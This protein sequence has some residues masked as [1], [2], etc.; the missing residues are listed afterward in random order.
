VA[1]T[2]TQLDVIASAVFCD[3][4]SSGDG[5]TPEEAKCQDTTAKALSNFASKKGLCYRKCRAD[6]HKGKI[7]AGSCTPPASDP[8][9]TDCIS[10]LE[11]KTAT[12]ID[13]KCEPLGGDRP[14]CYGSTD[15]AGWAGLVETGVDSASGQDQGDLYCQS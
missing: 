6:E 15:G 2:E 7:P 12:L 4:S 1:S 14:E 9:T 10:K 11:T 8:K 5:L 3:D 13:K